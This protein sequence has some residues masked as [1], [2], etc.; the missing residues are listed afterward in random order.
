MRHLQVSSSHPHKW[1]RSLSALFLCVLFVPLLFAWFIASQACVV[2]PLF[3]LP[4]CLGSNPFAL[5][6]DMFFD[7]HDPFVFPALAVASGF[8]LLYGLAMA[9]YIA[10]WGRPRFRFYVALVGVYLL[11]QTIEL[12]IHLLMFDGPQSRDYLHTIFVR[13]LISLYFILI[14]GVFFAIL[15]RL[16]FGRLNE[17]HHS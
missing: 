11:Y 12:I 6:E 17:P 8:G 14:F 4:I 3:D 5:F 7:W 1:K 13:L 10:K 2:A 15:H 9:V 16:L